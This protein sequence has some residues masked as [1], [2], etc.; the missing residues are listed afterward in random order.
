MAAGASYSYMLLPGKSADDTAAYAASPAVQI[1]QNDASAQAVMHAGLGIQAVNF[2]TAGSVAGIS[3]DSIASVVTHQ[4]NG[5]L[6]I[7]VSDPTQANTG[8]I[9]I[10]IASPA[11]GVVSQDPAVSVD[12]IS[13][14]VRLSVNVS[15]S[16]GKSLRVSLMVNGQ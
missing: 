2:W 11:S 5:L 9:H 7:A 4:A 13:P 3:S 16:H 15:A 10:E 8:V 14:T 1:L 6:N 12:Q